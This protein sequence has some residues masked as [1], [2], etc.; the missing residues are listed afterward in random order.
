MKIQKKKGK[1]ILLITLGSI[2]SILILIIIYFNISYSPLKSSFY[3]DLKKLSAKQ[4]TDQ[5]K[6]VFTEKDIENLPTALQKYFK[7]C[8]FLGANKMSYT[9]A[10]YKNVDFIQG[11]GGPKVTIDYTT[12]NFIYR[13]Q[14]IALINSSMYGIPFEGYDSYID[15]KGRMKGVVAKNI[16]LFNEVGPEMDK[17]ALVTYLGECLFVPSV[18]LKEFIRWEEIDDTHVKATI[19]DY[20]IS[21]EGIFTF[22]E[23]GEML[24]FVTKDR[25]VTNSDGSKE[26]VDW[27]G[28]CNNYIENNGIKQPSHF[29][30]VWHYKDGDFVYFNCNN[31]SMEYY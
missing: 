18:A 15:Q 9:K 16:T 12:Y 27:S 4:A 23:K 8:G 21:A 3:K 7:Y 13:P 6:E 19:T 26:N 2:F 25:A 11:K 29:E 30:A 24:E 5:S 14:R 22:S 1:K 28:I 20:N 17:A 10:Y 31:I